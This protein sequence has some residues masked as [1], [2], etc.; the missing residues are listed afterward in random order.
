M[1][2]KSMTGFARSAGSHASWRWNWEIKA[3][4][5]RGLDLRVRVP[6]GFDS[7]ETEARSRLG[8]VLV[9]G[10]CYANLSAQR[11]Q[12]TPEIRINDAALLALVAAVERLPR[13][14]AIQ[15]ATM[16]GLLSVR[17]IV[18]VVEATDSSESIAEISA[19][20]LASLDEAARALVSMRA[21]EGEALQRVLAG[22]LARLRELARAAHENP[23]RK[24][25][26]VRARLEQL[27][28]ELS[29][30]S[31]GFDP[32]RLHQ[33]AVLLAAKADVR[34][35]IDRLIAH[36]DAASELLNA[37]GAVGRR[38]DFLAQEMAREANT[39][40]SKSNDK[41]LTAIGMELRALIEQF[42]EQVQNIE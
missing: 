37:G 7:I 35:E 42:R 38:L 40:C 2:L 39:L 33:E 36:L 5:A 30:H 6:S 4:N 3:V 23:G 18:E 1:S 11:E 21:G 14:Q 41:D 15:P 24:P 27:V 9:R 10:T 13:S 29:S 20:M 25:E 32:Q 34:E 26:A 19:A 17:G 31:T 12:S 28:S 22:Q 16:D 8:A